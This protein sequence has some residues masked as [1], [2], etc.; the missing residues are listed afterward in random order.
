MSSEPALL[1]V[2]HGECAEFGD[3]TISRCGVLLGSRWSLWTIATT[4]WASV[5]SAGATESAGA[6]RSTTE[7][8]L[9]TSSEFWWRRHDFITGKFAVFVLVQFLQRCNGTFDLRSGELTILIRVESGHNR[10]PLH[11][12]THHSFR[13]AGTS[14]ATRSTESRSTESATTTSTSLALGTAVTTVWPAFSA[15]GTTTT[16]ATTS[17][18]GHHGFHFLFGDDA[19]AVCIGAREHGL[20][21]LGDF[22]EFSF[23]NR[24][25]FVGI[26]SFQN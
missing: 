26:K 7:S 10:Q 25:V 1:L 17:T 19:I 23:R 21:T 3:R 15:T 4:A 11:H 14:R 18:L 5:T 13:S 8:S 6:T 2:D 9:T 16:L 12:H 24:T 22:L 20:G